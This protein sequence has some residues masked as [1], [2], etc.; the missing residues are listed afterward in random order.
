MG[1]YF[2]ALMVQLWCS[3]FFIGHQDEPLENL[4]V[5][6]ITWPAWGEIFFSS[7]VDG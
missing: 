6:V 5:R 1:H 3:L 2:T 4:D 7:L